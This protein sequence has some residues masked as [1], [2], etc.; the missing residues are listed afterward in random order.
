MNEYSWNLDSGPHLQ[1]FGILGMRWGV[2]RYQNADGSY[3][4]AGKDRYFDGHDYKKQN[5]NVK[6]K[7]PSDAYLKDVAKA[8][9]KG[10]SE[11]DAEAA[12]KR[13]Q[14]IRKAIA[15]SAGIAVAAIATY[16]GVKYYKNNIQDVIVGTASTPLKR[17][18]TFDGKHNLDGAIYVANAKDNARYVDWWGR[19]QYNNINNAKNFARAGLADRN[20]LDKDVY[21]MD[22]VYNGGKGVKVASTPHARKIFNQMIKTDPEFKA[23]VEEM[24]NKSKTKYGDNLYDN[25][26]IN[27]AGEGRKSDAVKKFYQTMKDRG[28]GGIK[29]VNDNKYSGFETKSAALI[30]SGGYDWKAHKLTDN[31]FAKAAEDNAKF[32]AELAAKENRKVLVKNIGKEAG[33][34]GALGAGVFA[35]SRTKTARAT[36]MRNA[37]VPVSKIAKQLGIPESEVYALTSESKK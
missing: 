14:K 26:N 8:K 32:A 22:L 9:S 5:V 1:H 31:D 12:A 6:T 35:A 29:D 7:K 16:A 11:E 20:V 3:T 36:S 15:I 33:V 10:M 13:K 30:F 25:F 24:V 23:Q 4:N 28:Y 34:Y 17:V 19:E 27:M 21:N 37:G 2:R 18:Q